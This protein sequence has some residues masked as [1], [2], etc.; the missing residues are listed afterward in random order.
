VAQDGL[1]GAFTKAVPKLKNEEP[2]SFSCAVAGGTAFVTSKGDGEWHGPT[3]NV[4]LNIPPSTE[5]GYGFLTAVSCGHFDSDFLFFVDVS[6]GENGWSF[7]IRIAGDTGQTVW[8]SENAGF[9]TSQ[10][11]VDG[12]DM[13]LSSIGFVGKLSLDTGKFVWRHDGLYPPY[14]GFGSPTIQR[15]VAFPGFDELAR[16]MHS[17]LVVD[18]DTGRIVSGATRSAGR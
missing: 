4:R 3:R 18:A 1:N 17:S 2:E 14:N 13:Y 12:R 10:P 9:N 6:S 11:L 7:A 16:P 5:P 15:R 8:R